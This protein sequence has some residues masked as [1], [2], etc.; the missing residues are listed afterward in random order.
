M[1]FTALKGTIGDVIPDGYE[2][3]TVN[4]PDEEISLALAP[5]S[6]NAR[7]TPSILLTM[8]GYKVLIALKERLKELYDK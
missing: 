8:F 3:Y 1:F 5:L 6:I 2:P 7:K 4:K